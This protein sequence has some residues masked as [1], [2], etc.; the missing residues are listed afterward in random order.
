[1]AQRRRTRSGAK[2]PAPL[3]TAEAKI[4]EIGAR[5]D[6]VALI[7]GEKIFVPCSAPGD[8]ARIAYRGSRGAIETLIAKSQQRVSA[9]CPYFGECGGCALQQLNTDYYRGWK[10]ELVV[11]ALAREGFDET[12]IAPP[13]RL[14]HAPRRRASFAVRRT[15]SGVVFG[16]HER[17]SARI[18]A[19]KECLVLA[20]KL[21]AMLPSLRALAEKAPARWRIFDLH[22]TLCDNGLDIA[23]LGGDA[24]DD[25][26]GP[27]IMALTETAQDAG[28][29]RI[30]ADGAPVAM[31]EAPFV[32]FGGVA[33]AI[34]PGAFL[35]ASGEGEAALTGFVAE[36]AKGAKRIADLFS[37]CGTFALA[38]SANA[39]VDAFDS[40]PPAIAALDAGA[41]SASL[42][43]PLRA[44]RRNLF[45]RPLSA[46]ELKPYDAV[47]FDPPRAGAKAQAEQLAQSSVP[48]VIGVSCNPASFAR[49]AGLLRDGGYSLSQVLPVDQFVFSAHVE[50]AGLFTKE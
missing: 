40:D 25:L 31:F 26:T 20:P 10:R 27:E 49:D 18:V 4:E 13:L 16:F 46:E 45:E 2:T 39:A 12:I 28:V 14:A 15:G 21:A 7:D 35:Q 48:V 5:G 36:H 19:I 41:R 34:P 38:L 1:M 17:A 33:V 6:G 42:R 30:T 50:V 8:V 37:G 23:F 44:E 24:S 43:H 9:P 32:R 22:V 11:K 29:V 3:K 47:V